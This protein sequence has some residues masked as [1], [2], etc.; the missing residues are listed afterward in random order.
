MVDGCQH[1]PNGSLLIFRDAQQLHGA[2][3]LGK[4]SPRLLLVFRLR[5]GERRKGCH[6]GGT[7]SHSSELRSVCGPRGWFTAAVNYPRLSRAGFGRH[8]QTSGKIVNVVGVRFGVQGRFYSFWKDL[9]R[10]RFALS[11]G[12]DVK[13]KEPELQPELKLGASQ[14]RSEQT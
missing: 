8:V 4:C 5:E 10:L 12:L 11:S 13:I 6:G 14:G 3:E 7:G 2:L 9:S 1:P